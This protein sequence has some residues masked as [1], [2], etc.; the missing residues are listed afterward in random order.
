MKLLYYTLLPF[1]NFLH[2]CYT[3]SITKYGIVDEL[4]MI[5]KCLTCFN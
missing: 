2:F 3:L 5:Y 4:I 1:L